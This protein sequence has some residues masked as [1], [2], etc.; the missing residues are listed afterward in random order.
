MQKHRGYFK[1]SICLVKNKQNLDEFLEGLDL[2]SEEKIVNSPN[3]IVDFKDTL[4][5][6]LKNI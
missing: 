4:L 3:W 1:E 6:A 2:K 5:N